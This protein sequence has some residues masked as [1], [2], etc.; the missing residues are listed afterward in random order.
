VPAVGVLTVVVAALSV[1][2]VVT[3]LSAVTVLPVVAVIAVLPVGVVVLAVALVGVAW[4]RRG[5]GGCHRQLVRL[6]R[7]VRGG[8]RWGRGMA[9]VVTPLSVVAA[10]S[11]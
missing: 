3:V 1:V 11:P 2:A 6:L 10:G 5:R 7:G 4:L 8:R 9:P